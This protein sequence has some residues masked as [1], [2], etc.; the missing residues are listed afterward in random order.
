MLVVRS[1]LNAPSFHLG[2]AT[3]AGGSREERALRC[4]GDGVSRVGP[5]VFNGVVS[6]ECYSVSPLPLV[7]PA[8][9]EVALTH[10]RSTAQPHRMRDPEFPSSPAPGPG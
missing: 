1:R 8:T 2:D 7:T 4:A 9:P 6:R 5:D 3:L 10:H